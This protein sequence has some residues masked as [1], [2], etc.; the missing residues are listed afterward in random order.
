[1][2]PGTNALAIAMAGPH[3]I[4]R[5]DIPT[6][7]I[8]VWAGTSEENLRD[9][10]IKQ[11]L[12]A[13]PSGLATDGHHLFVADSE[14]SALRSIELG[15]KPYVHTIVGLGLFEFDDRDG[16]G[17]DVRLQHCLGVAYGNGKLYVADTYNNKI[18]VCDP[19]AKSVETLVGNV[20]S[21]KT[22]NPPRF[23]Q[24]GGLSVAGTKLYVADTNNQA[25]RVVDLNTNAVKT[26]ELQGLKP[27]TPPRRAPRFP[28][29]V[30]IDLPA[31][32][33]KPSAQVAFHVE[34]PLE[35]GYKLNEEVAM[36]YL[37]ESPKQEGLLAGDEAS[38]HRQEKP[39]KSLDIKVALAKTPA[40]GESTSIKLSLGTFVCSENSS[41]CRVKNFVWNVPITFDSGG[42]DVVKIQS[43][44]SKQAS[45]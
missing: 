4:W 20:G 14:V 45:R 33:V 9:G 34:V 18:K 31:V 35:A 42:T 5:Y 36:P 39:S 32:K 29:P 6:K 7:V 8:E 43:D 41:L 1:L 30:V 25:I 21:G 24:P 15:K 16:V 23:Y 40:T 22:D 38:G 10:P 3:Q 37:F 11:A 28:N 27:P 19:A 12:F 17:E 2:I 26:L 44:S 13:Q